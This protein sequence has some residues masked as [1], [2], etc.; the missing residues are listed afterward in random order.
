LCK[1]CDPDLCDPY[2]F[3]LD[4]YFFDLFD[5]DFD[6][7]PSLFDRNPSLFDRNPNW[8]SQCTKATRR[9]MLYAG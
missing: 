8:S 2:L 4:T 5:F 3:D 1:I 9:R 6:R 7:N